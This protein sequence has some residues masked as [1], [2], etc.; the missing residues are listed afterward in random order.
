MN[1]KRIIASLLILVLLIQCLTVVSL[2]ASPAA[3]QQFKAQING[4]YVEITWEKVTSGINY[5]SIERSTDSG[6]F[7]TIATFQAGINSFKDYGVSNGHI[8]RYRARNYNSSG[9]SAYTGETEI[10]LLYPTSLT[11]TNYYSNQVNLVWTY[12]SLAHYRTVNIKTMVERREDG[13]SSWEVVY[14]A[15]YPETE[16]WDVGLKPN[17]LYHY[18]IRTQYND[19]T[20]SQ[21]IPYGTTKTVRTSIPLTTSL[22]GFALSDS[23]IRL[24]WDASVLSNYTLCLQKQ[25]SEGNFDTIYSTK[26]VDHYTEYGLTAGKSYYYRIYLYSDN[27]MSSPYSE[28]IEIMTE[29]IPAPS[30]GAALPMAGGQITVTWNYPYEVESGFEIFRK[31]GDGPFE[32]IAV[33]S[34]NSSSYQDHSAVYGVSYTY[35]VRAYR[36]SNVYSAFTT[37]PEIINAQPTEPPQLLM[38]PME[39]YLLVGCD[40][41]PD[42][43]TYVLEMRTDGING[44]WTDIKSASGGALMTYLFPEEG[45]AVELRLRAEN[46]GN[47][48]YGPVYRLFGSVPETPTDLKITGLGSNRV[49]LA[50]TDITEKEEGYRIYRTVSGKRSL[51]ATLSRDAAG[52]TD[53]QPIAGAQAKYEIVAYNVMGEAKP[54]SILA[55]VPQKPSFKD[56]A[57]LTWAA[58]GIDALCGLGAI[59]QSSDRLFYPNKT[60]TRAEFITMMFKTY[61]ITPSGDYLFSLKDV[62][63]NAWYYAYMMSA[64]KCGIIIP[65]ENGKAYPEAALTREDLAVFLANLLI[66]RGRPMNVYSHEVLNRYRDS[67]LIPEA[68]KSVFASL[69][70]D[71]I[72]PPQGGQFLNY[73]APVTRAEGAAVLYKFL[74][75]YP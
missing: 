64:V 75:V 58:P 9:F 2:A 41:A 52:F 14:E 8:Y 27:G 16:F 5:T 33:L 34:K 54:A 21:Y 12:P 17:T 68:L 60:I 63:R 3:P 56:T 70:A 6:D 35:K 51:L 1:K 15:P 30:N 72:F 43:I 20:Y 24:E 53:N 73:Q 55:T 47:I 31:E 46:K 50:W 7:Q 25:D 48:R 39:G 18:R 49:M 71:S 62:P 23:Q 26:T 40:S 61:G 45:M 11:A 4:S 37:T 13:K 57:N 44:Q 67:Y 10:A 29:S 42:G 66:Y 74:R 28:L 38:A 59:T 36:G 19:G 22:W 32:R 65:D 69:G